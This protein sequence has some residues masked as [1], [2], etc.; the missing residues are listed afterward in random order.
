VAQA[1]VKFG[2]C[3]CRSVYTCF[4]F[5]LFE[6]LFSVS[7]RYY[8]IAQKQSFLIIGPLSRR[9]LV[10]CTLMKAPNK[11]N[12]YLHIFM[13]KLLYRG[14]FTATIGYALTH[15]ATCTPSKLQGV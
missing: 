8:D 4:A 15:L 1:N 14:H 10:I 2:E 6:P 3:I 7:H 9:P 13:Q 11:F 12:L 5:C